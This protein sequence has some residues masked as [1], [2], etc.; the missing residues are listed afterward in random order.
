MY[1]ELGRGQDYSWSATTSGQDII[2][3]YAVELCQDD[4]H[5]LYHGTC[6]AMEQ[7][8]QKN[9]WKPTVADGTA[10]GSYTMRVWRTKYG[11]VAYRAT[12]GGKKVAYTTLRSSYLHEPTPS[13]ASRCS[14]TPLRQG[15]RGLPERGAA[16][17][18]HLQLVLRRLPAHRLL[19]QR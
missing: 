10:A 8:E 4:H 14:T 6:T 15:T 16:H 13:S 9:A 11:P 7:V 5:Y 3:T 17:Q 18:L 1:V 12:V 19:Q 2:D